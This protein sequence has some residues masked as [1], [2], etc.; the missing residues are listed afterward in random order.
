[1]TNIQSKKPGCIKESP[2][3]S[4]DELIESFEHSY[5]EYSLTLKE[6]L[7]RRINKELSDDE[8]TRVE[9]ISLSALSP[10]FDMVVNRGANKENIKSEMDRVVNM[11]SDDNR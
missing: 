10:I 1:M 4:N 3:L 6:I 8:Y 9:E 11:F 5:I 2:V 7:T